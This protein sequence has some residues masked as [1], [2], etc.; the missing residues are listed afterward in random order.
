MFLLRCDKVIVYSSL[1][2]LRCKKQSYF[3]YAVLYVLK[4]ML[5]EMCYE[6]YFYISLLKSYTYD[7][8]PT[9]VYF[10]KVK[11]QVAY[12]FAKLV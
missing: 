1:K 9:A 5:A 2:F 7:N 3:S 4:Q 11:R 10:I 6:I 8:L 12:I